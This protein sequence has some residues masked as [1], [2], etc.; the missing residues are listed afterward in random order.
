M[1]LAQ[2][3][4]II[5]LPDHISFSSLSQ[6]V[7]C[8]EKW[9]LMHGY[10]ATAH[11]WYATIAG[12]VIHAITETWDKN[13]Y[14][15]N[16]TDIPSFGDLFTEEI[17]RQVGDGEDI[18]PSGRTCKTVCESGGPN[19]K[20]YDWWMHYGP[21]YVDRWTTWRKRHTEY[22]IATIN[23]QPGIEYPVEATLN[24]DTRVV[25]YIDRILHNPATGEYTILDLKTGAIPQGNLQLYTYRHLL[26]LKDDIQ[27][28]YGMFWT[29]SHKTASGDTNTGYDTGPIPL[30]T[31]AARHI[32]VM[33][34][35]AMQGIAN[36]VF[37]P[38]VTPMCKG[39][40]VRD[41]C[42]AYG[43]PQAYRYPTTTIT[44]PQ[45]SKEDKE[46]Q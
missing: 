10:H 40:P 45:H 13:L 27:P 42:W 11:T 35:S 23:G 43:G 2:K 24:H 15:H 38:H 3:P 32:G 17:I 20:D 33:Y 36:N 25:G 28:A 1:P 39:C 18:R 8:G 37:I 44:Q 26:H 5:D 19:K 4:S 22:E 46:H 16:D 41:S 12:S 6:W 31:E 34:T 21:I 14:H 7:E 9:R 29:P 30:D